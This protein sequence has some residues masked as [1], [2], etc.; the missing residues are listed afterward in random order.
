VAWTRFLWLGKG[1]ADDCC[2]HINEITGY[3]KF[4]EFVAL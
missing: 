1:Y 3:I 2:E 4:G